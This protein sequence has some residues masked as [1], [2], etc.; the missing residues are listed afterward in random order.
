MKW[1]APADRLV[2]SIIM[3]RDSV[4]REVVLS[5]TW[6]FRLGAYD[7]GCRSRSSEDRS[8]STFVLWWFDL[9]LV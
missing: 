5:E 4:T 2:D 8:H 7:R 1:I 6:P 3:K 9:L